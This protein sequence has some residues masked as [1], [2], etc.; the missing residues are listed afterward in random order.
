MQNK[1]ILTLDL[2][3]GGAVIGMV[4]VHTFLT[5]ANVNL[6]DAN[7]L[8]YAIGALGRGTAVFLI[9][10]GITFMTSKN[11]SVISA[12]KRA[13]TLVL[14][15]I[16]MNFLKFMIP[17]FFNA[18]PS[19]FMDKFNWGD[20]IPLG[21]KYL[22]L[23]LL[24]DILQLAGMSLFFIGF[25]RKYVSNKFGILA[26]GIAVAAVSRELNGFIID[27]PVLNYI[28][29]LLFVNKYP[30]RIFFPV[31]P[32][33]S[34]II[35][36]MFFGKWFEEMKYDQPALVKKMLLL[37]S[38]FI[39]M[40]A[41]LVYFFR[42][43]HYNGFFKMGFGGVMYYGGWVLIFL[44][45]LYQFTNYM[46]RESLII[47]TLKYCSKNLTT[48]YVIQWALISWG[49]GIFGY[50]NSRFASVFL[51]IILFMILTFLL[52]YSIDF[53]LNL[54][55]KEYTKIKLKKT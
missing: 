40:G 17:I 4:I 31:F 53:I 26:I 43:Y 19:N 34:F 51:L 11:Q 37:G 39:I 12:I 6:R 36:G 54:K 25:I 30:A 35:I 46:N 3:K 29:D 33:I 8:G 45:I 44:W 32:W 49:K 28:T 55:N 2:I 15:G 27:L 47:R 42:D 48:M 52:Q 1:R 24:G 14:V 21:M 41:P 23:V 7:I 22:Y 5:Y 38:V 13:F 16:L 18:M 20:E 50:R 10:M 9:S